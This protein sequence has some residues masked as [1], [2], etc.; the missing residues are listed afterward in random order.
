MRSYKPQVLVLA[1]ENKKLKKRI[2]QLEKELQI[3]NNK[4]Y[5]KFLFVEDGSVDSDNLIE[6]L[7]I[8]NPEI[9]VVIYRKSAEKPIILNLI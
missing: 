4:G 6:D 8:K 1:E 9:K 3:K 2:L 7:K 5:T